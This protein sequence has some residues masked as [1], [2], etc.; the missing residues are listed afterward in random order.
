MGDCAYTR[1][2]VIMKA[3]AAWTNV[4]PL[5][6]YRH[7][8][9]GDTAVIHIDIFCW[10]EINVICCIESLSM[11][12]VVCSFQIRSEVNLPLFS[13]FVHVHH[14]PSVIQS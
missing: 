6:E 3:R 9:R 2:I 12:F 5:C 1:I 8:N 11:M 13:Q 14:S 4:E 7:V 10:Y